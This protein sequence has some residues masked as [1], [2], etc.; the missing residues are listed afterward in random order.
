MGSAIMSRDGVPIISHVLSMPSSQNFGETIMLLHLI[1]C[2]M[3]GLVASVWASLSVAACGGGGAPPSSPAT[4]GVSVTQPV[5]GA[6]QLVAG[7]GDAAVPPV[8]QTDPVKEFQRT[9]M[10]IGANLGNIRR[11]TITHEFTDL[12]MAS[13]GFGLTTSFGGGDAI[14][15]S[16]G[17]PTADFSITPW[18]G[19]SKT[20]GLG[21][22]YKVVFDGDADL[23]LAASDG[24]DPKNPDAQL[25][26][27]TKTVDAQTKKT[28]IDLKIKEGITQLCLIFRHKKDASGKPVSLVKNLQIIRPGYDW[29]SPPI[30]T[31]PFLS[32]ISRFSTLRFMDWLQTNVDNGASYDLSPGDWSQRPTPVNKRVAGGANVPRGQ[33][34]ERIV[35]LANLTGVN[36]WINVP[37]KANDAYYA[38]LAHFLNTKLTRDQKI[39]IEYGNEMWNLGMFKQAQAVVIEAVAEVNAGTPLGKRLSAGLP[40]GAGKTATDYQFEL[41]QRLYADRLARISEAFRAE[42]GND[43]MMTRIRPVLA[44]QIGAPGQTESMIKY[45]T[46]SFGKPASY[47][48]QSIAGAPYFFMTQT[49]KARANALR[50]LALSNN[51]NTDAPEYTLSVDDILNS[52]KAY[53]DNVWTGYWYEANLSIAKRYGL[54]WVAYEGGPDTAGAASAKNK[55]AASRDFRMYDMCKSYLETWSNSGGGLFMWF[56]GGAGPWDDEYG[57]WPLVEQIGDTAGPKIQ[58]MDWAST[59]PASV[60]LGKRHILPGTFSSGETLKDGGLTSEQTADVAADKVWYAAGQS[61]NYVVST[62]TSA[63]FKV[64]V[65]VTNTGYSSATTEL[66]FEFSLDDAVVSQTP[67]PAAI[68]PQATKTVTLDGLKVCMTPGIHVIGVKLAKSA[69]LRTGNIDFSAWPQ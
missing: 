57:S 63:C 55:G 16:D 48:F 31:K 60:P 12:V 50:A 61:R 34:W 9:Q 69:A 2:R 53:I 37:P 38:E 64:S 36:I 20:K 44:W 3:R 32:H 25:L 5:A 56:S 58:C 51:A 68:A 67:I 62:P 42:F 52:M 15:G 40:I 46:S 18:T 49:D 10:R 45:V 43:K 24:P 33:P 66:P 41:G 59:T 26:Q 35:E 1:P 47:Y 54:E 27:N 7:A 29:R 4:Q 23:E 14:L 13:E 65:E 19:Q 6:E 39:Y 8:V 28:I 22:V 21:G 11:Y 17:W 30:F